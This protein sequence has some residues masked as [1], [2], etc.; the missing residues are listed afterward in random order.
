M[1]AGMFDFLTGARA[2]KQQKAIYRATLE[3]ILCEKLQQLVMLVIDDLIALHR[4]TEQE[5]ASLAED[6]TQLLIGMQHSL[7][8]KKVPNDPSIPER[9]KAGAAV[10]HSVSA[11][12]LLSMQLDVAD[13]ASVFATVQD[14]RTIGD[15]RYALGF[16]RDG[17]RQRSIRHRH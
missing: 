12:F 5:R 9:C 8:G 1:V 10:A 6:A 11:S 4:L 17:T 2:L 7:V 3:G 14:D 16:S 15:I 13:T